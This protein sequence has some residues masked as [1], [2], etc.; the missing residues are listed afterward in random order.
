M[1]R[2]EFKEDSTLGR[3]V[4]CFDGVDDGLRYATTSD[5]YEKLTKNFTIEL[6]Y[7][8]LEHR[9][10]QPGWATHRV[11]VSALNRKA[12]PTPCSFGAHIGGAYQK[13]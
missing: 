11:P 12:T 9:E 4:A 3:T 10:Q 1:E 5:D 2:R 8:P 13:A 7:K 6:Y